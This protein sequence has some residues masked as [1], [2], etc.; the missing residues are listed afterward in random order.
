MAENSKSSLLNLVL[1]LQL[2]PCPQGPQ[3]AV[4]DTSKVSGSEHVSRDRFLDIFGSIDFT[5]GAC[6]G[7]SFR[8][9]K[10]SRFRIVEFSF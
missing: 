9:L 1:V 3:G 6:L 7:L 10:Q 2:L 4:E 5:D 8:V